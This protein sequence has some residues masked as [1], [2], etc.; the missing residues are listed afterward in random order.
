M[1]F[2]T[3]SALWVVLEL[4]CLAATIWLLARADR[5]PIPPIVL[6]GA[7]LA[8][9]GWTPVFYELMYGQ[10][11]LP[12]LALLAGARLAQARARPRPAGALV[13]CAGLLKPTPRVLI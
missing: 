9:V 10:L 8:L 12:A 13:V 4:L 1:S 7:T 11:T 2:P 6:V 3:A 5:V